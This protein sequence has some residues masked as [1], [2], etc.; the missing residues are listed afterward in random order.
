MKFNEG[1]WSTIAKLYNKINREDMVDAMKAES[2]DFFLKK[3][4]G[5]Y[6]GSL[7]Y[8]ALESCNSLFLETF[9]SLFKADLS[10][11]STVYGQLNN[12]C[13]L[14]EMLLDLCFPNEHYPYCSLYLNDDDLMLK[15]GKITSISNDISP[16]IISHNIDRAFQ[17]NLHNVQLFYFEEIAKDANYYHY[18]LKFI[19]NTQNSYSMFLKGIEFYNKKIEEI[20]SLK[21][22]KVIIK[23][24]FNDFKSKAY[25]RLIVAQP[26]VLVKSSGDLDIVTYLL[27]IIPDKEQYLS[28]LYKK[29]E[30]ASLYKL[31][32]K[33]L[34]NSPA[35]VLYAAIKG[36]ADF[37]N[38][39]MD[40]G[41]KLSDKEKLFIKE[42]NLD[43]KIKNFEDNIFKRYLTQLQDKSEDDK[44][45]YLFNALVTNNITENDFNQLI[46]KIDLNNVENESYPLVHGKLDYEKM[47]N[48]YLNGS[49]SFI[50]VMLKTDK[51]ISLLDTQS[52]SFS[53]LQKNY[54]TH[55]IIA[56]IKNF[57][58]SNEYE[59]FNYENKLE[60]I[61][62][63]INPDII[64]LVYQSYLTSGQEKSSFKD[65]YIL[66]RKISKEEIL[67]NKDIFIVQ[68]L[69]MIARF[70]S[71][72]GILNPAE[73]K[74]AFSLAHE[75]LKSFSLKKSGGREDP[76][77]V[78]RI[79]KVIGEINNYQNGFA[80]GVIK[81]SEKLTN[82]HEIFIQIDK[83]ILTR[84][85][86][87]YGI[88]RKSH[89]SLRL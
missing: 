49:A 89:S 78:H 86:K 20:I 37:I 15:N 3:S 54:L 62:R 52:L 11:C 35:P 51:I 43:G 22:N 63:K 66:S 58:F 39:I 14:N 40:Y 10:H 85:I 19:E 31:K 29:R 71:E 1:E 83:E 25:N 30:K 69:P 68:S 5:I 84:G 80:E 61:Q 75:A 46:S 16:V 47:V 42:L 9:Y 33:G 53:Y 77:N 59:N 13:K 56:Q 79:A 4:E 60:E 38:F 26:E 18:F 57:R 67:K 50:D 88:P 2:V 45:Y 76:E 6:S 41:Y 81:Q 27:K 55:K 74:V 24:S 64:S 17:H 82:L 34:Y 7:F 12:A 87:N 32:E 44:A 65:D 48:N 28:L 8:Q 36:N 72:G 23:E 21:E 73:Q 70:L